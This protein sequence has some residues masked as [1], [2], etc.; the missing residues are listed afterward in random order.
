MDKIDVDSLLERMTMEQ[1]VSLLSGK[2]FWNL[3]DIKELGIKGPM[4]SDG[5]HGLR[6]QRAEKDHLGIAASQKA[7]CFPPAVTLASSWDKDLLKEVGQAL[8]EECQ[9]ENVAVLL[10]PGINIKR[11]PLCGRNFEY[12]SEDPL[13]SGELG[14]SFIQGVQS[15]GIGTSLKHF[16][17]NNQEHNRLVVD[18][19]IDQR[20]LREI[21]L[22]GFEIAVKKSQPWTVMCSYNKINGEYASENNWLLNEVLKDEWGHQGLV[23]TDWGAANDRRKGLKAGLELEMP[24]SGGVNDQLVIQGVKA[25]EI[26]MDHLDRA[27]GRIL[28]LYKKAAENNRENVVYNREN[29]HQLALKAAEKSMVLLKNDDDLLPL[30]KNQSIAV[31]GAFAKTPRYQGAG[32]SQVTP[33]QLSNGY[34]ELCLYTG[35]QFPYAE[36]F[37]LDSEEILQNMVDEA[38]FQASKAEV[39]LLFAGLPPMFES[40]GF[41]R[42]TMEI[43]KNQQYLIEQLASLGKK[44]VILLSNGSPVEMPWLNHCQALLETYLGGQAGAEAAVRILFGEVNPSG[45]LAESF[46]KN[47]RDN[48]SYAHFPGHGRQVEYREGLYVGYRYYNSV[49]KNLLF[50]F[51]YGLSY[52]EYI[53]RDLKISKNTWTK[54]EDLS[55]S[56]TLTNQGDMDGMETAQFYIKKV[57][58]NNYRP[59]HEL[60]GFCKVELK[61]SE[62]K[63]I[64]YSLDEEAFQFYHEETNSWQIEP[65]VYTLQIG[66]SSRNIELEAEITIQSDFQEAF[67]GPAIY[68]N[69]PAENFSPGDRD[70][71]ELLGREIPIPE[72]TKP[73]HRNSTLGEIKK[74]SKG[75]RIYRE[76]SK[77]IIKLFENQNDPEFMN[78]IIRMIDGMPLRSMVLM[79]QGKMSYAKLDAMIYML[80]NRGLK[81]LWKFLRTK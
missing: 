11:S 57:E 77:R 8:G 67:S 19:V 81:G 39:I 79:G 49:N 43:P 59:Y 32:S 72:E 2:D 69:P 68:M 54:G 64:S 18:A 27:V 58:R 14:A 17:A 46:P 34:D 15:Q 26:S 25:G 63:E 65:G 61:K 33:T 20:T 53:Y 55:F 66:S 47:L 29:H 74:T 3:Q 9:E 38:L 76:V 6:V 12:Y 35:S 45:K 1:K 7:T 50:P 30:Q 28:K 52:G 41:D 10:G 73:F 31:I 13:L 60:K 71:Q 24:S 44:I 42:S 4:V 22:K 70:F 16:A 62:S 5:P 40:E 78:M 80:N 75:K 56:F 37:L 48:P 36:G 21:Y 51:G 23:I